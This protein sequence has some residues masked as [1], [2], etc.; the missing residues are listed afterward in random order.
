MPDKDKQ[1]GQQG[2]SKQAPGRQ[3]EEQGGRQGQKGNQQ[4]GRQGQQ[5]GGQKGAPQTNR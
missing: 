4:G 1:S 2:G 3:G 5:G